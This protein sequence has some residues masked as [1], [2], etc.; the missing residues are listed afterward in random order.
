MVLL[1]NQGD[2]SSSE[3][4]ISSGSDPNQLN[5]TGVAG[6]MKVVLKVDIW[7]DKGKEK[8]MKTVSR[9]SGVKT[10]SID[11]KDLKL[12]VT[13]D[14]IDPILVA[15][16][17]RKL[18]YT[19]IVSVGPV[20]SS[21][22]I[23]RTESRRNELLAE[24][25]PMDD[26]TVSSMDQLLQRMDTSAQAGA[27]TTSLF[28]LPTHTCSPAPLYSAQAINMNSS[29]QET[30]QIL[31]QLHYE[32]LINSTSSFPPVML[33]QDRDN[34][35][36][37]DRKRLL[38][39]KEMSIKRIDDLEELLAARKALLTA[40]SV[41]LEELIAK[42]EQIVELSRALEE[43]NRALE[44]EKMKNA[45]F[46]S[47]KENDYLMGVA[48]CRLKILDRYPELDLSWMEDYAGKDKGGSGHRG[49]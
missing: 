4:P 20:A 42:D 16:K 2:P 13:G 36:M 15:C 49:A 3:R 41:V 6:K 1:T 10:V 24:K 34:G 30:A 44:V 27:S 46:A 48:D 31:E 25:S 39:E 9:F 12:T 5:R 17:L 26:A 47:S 32:E 43:L 29:G 8:A 18:F 7:D 38:N 19:E 11:M 33:T 14:G 35:V 22:I 40:E 21:L 23:Q 28:P 45:Y 37:V